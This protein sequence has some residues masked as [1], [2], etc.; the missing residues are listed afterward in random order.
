LLHRRISCIKRVISVIERH[1]V[2]RQLIPRR[3][4][5]PHVRSKVDAFHHTVPTAT[6]ICMSGLSCASV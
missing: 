1:S 2:K 3:R 4:Q 5:V 6:C